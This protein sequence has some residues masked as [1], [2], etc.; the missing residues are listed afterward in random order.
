MPTVLA[1]LRCSH[2]GPTAA[3]TVF[4]TALALGAGR[5]G[6]ALWVAAAVLAGQLSVGWLNDC[7]DAERDRAAGR[8]DK[9][10]VAG[11]ITAATVG[12]AAAVALAACAALSLLSGLPAAV[13][14]LLA[15][16]AAWAYDLGLKATVFSVAPYAL[17]F[18]LLPAFVTL[19]PPLR[20]A[21]PA[22]AV[23]AGALLGAGAHFTNVLPDLATDAATGV[24]GLPHRLGRRRSTLV[25][26]LLLAAAGIAVAAGARPLP[27]LATA[28]LLVAGLLVGGVVAAG[29]AGRG[30][31]AFRLTMATAGALVL[32]FVSAGLRP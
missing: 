21:P 18:G 28:A 27:P 13:V 11:E 19:G 5:G 4:A 22:W 2:P 10:V 31:V 6:G 1:L 32:A 24:R 26:A 17:A 25:A 29:L 20:A 14:H 15:V 12:R 7:L 8:V 9:P 23:A 30:R 16:A 3:V